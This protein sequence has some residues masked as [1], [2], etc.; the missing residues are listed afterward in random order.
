MVEDKERHE[1]VQGAGTVDSSANGDSVH[2]TLNQNVC[3]ER[4]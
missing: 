4:M 3:R 1:I 2:L